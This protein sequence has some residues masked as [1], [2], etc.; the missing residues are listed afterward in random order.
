MG[1]S[2]LLILISRELI[3]SGY[4]NESLTVNDDEILFFRIVLNSEK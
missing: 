1:I 2:P 3:N 4:W